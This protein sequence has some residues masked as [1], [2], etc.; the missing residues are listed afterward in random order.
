LKVLFIQKQFFA[1]LGV[2][3][4]SGHLRAHGHETFALI[5]S[6]HRE[7]QLLSLIQEFGPDVI[8]FSLMSTEHTWFAELA[9]RIKAR[10]QSVPIVAGGIHAIL[11]PDDLAQL[12]AVDYVCHGEGEETFLQ[13]IQYLGGDVPLHQVR[14]IAY[15]QGG[16]IEKTALNPFTSLDVFREDR[17]V[18]YDRYPVLRDMPLKVFVSSRGCPHR[19]SF[20]VNPQL[21]VNFKGLGAYVR[22][23]SVV[24]FID[25]MLEVKDR[26]GMKSIFIADDLFVMDKMWLRDF[27][28]Q[29]RERIGI[30]FICTC[31]AD[32]L[33]AEVAALLVAS[34]CHTVTFG[35]ETGNE[36]LRIK[37]LKKRITNDQL[38]QAASVLTAAGLR[39]QTSNMFCLPGESVEDA[40]KTIDLNIRMGTSYTMSSIFMP[41]PKTELTEYCI[42]E[43][44]LKADYSFMDM[45][46][47]FITR[48]VLAIKNK[49][50]LERLQKVS[51][52]IVQYPRLRNILIFLA[53]RFK[54]YHAYFVLYLVGTVLRF[55]SE[56]KMNLLDTLKYIWTYRKNV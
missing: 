17:A 40:I 3:S 31:R 39:Y 54:S 44:M 12:P 32:M 56:R 11:Y 49:D 5:G 50:T 21:Q 30:P 47:S 7:A 36:D 35:V 53:L 33:D 25:E 28:P 13:L 27:A 38:M 51:G 24:R 55:R 9:V 42:R 6:Q 37:I 20:C 18:Y 52:M 10:F 14:G 22:R 19:C 48:S 16:R 29:Y 46:H 34:G 2:M 4:L 26:Y 8:G 41:F 1:Y 15:R 43:K 45:P 23:K